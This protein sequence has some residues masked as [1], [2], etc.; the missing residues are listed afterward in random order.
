TW[1][2]E[3]GRD[4]ARLDRGLA[5]VAVGKL[6]GAVGTLAQ[7]DA[8]VE[9]DALASLGLAP[10]PIATQVVHRDRHAAL[11]TD[12]AVTGGT[13][14]RIALEIRHLQRTEVREAAEP[15]AA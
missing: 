2:E 13:L 15:V 4:L 6:S 7:L 5:G 14:E 11:L 10:E 1:S 9:T 12:L 8:D 3:L